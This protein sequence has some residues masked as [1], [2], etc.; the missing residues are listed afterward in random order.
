MG[1]GRAASLH[2]NVAEVVFASQKV[3]DAAFERIGEKDQRA[4]RWC[5]LFDFKHS[6]AAVAQ[7][8]LACKVVLGKV[9]FSSE[10]F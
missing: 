7:S 4:S 10:S 6:D 1:E 2:G 8:R 9:S 3:V 5:S